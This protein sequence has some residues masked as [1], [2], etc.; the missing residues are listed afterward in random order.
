MMQNIRSM[1]LCSHKLAGSTRI[2]V[3]YYLIKY[4]NANF[5]M[6]YPLS[7]VSKIYIFHG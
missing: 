2:A 6:T 1:Y 4:A 3:V 5:I 7:L